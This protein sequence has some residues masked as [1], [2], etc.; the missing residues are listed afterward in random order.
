M[1]NE[2]I[3]EYLINSMGSQLDLIFT[4][5]VAICGGIVVLSIQLVIQGQ[6][7]Q[8]LKLN[9][10]SRWVI[11]LS[12]LLVFITEGVSIF[13]GYLCRACIT[14]NIPIIFKQ[15]FSMINHWEDADFEGYSRLVDLF[16]WQ[17]WTFF[18]GILLLAILI[19]VLLIKKR[20][21]I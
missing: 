7:T 16:I 10:L 5:S 4:L 20:K 17:F 11:I 1:N 13:F 21:I 9:P 3:A 8:D 14:S 18:L 19:A 12:L 6:H 2:K 15:D